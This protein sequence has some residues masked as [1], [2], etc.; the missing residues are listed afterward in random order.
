MSS[1]LLALA[2]MV[3]ALFMGV[4]SPGPSFVMVART[5]M[6]SNRAHGIAASVGMG[7]GG[8]FYA[9][10]ALLGL[11]LVFNAVPA[12]YLMLKFVG[13]AYLI[14]LGVRIWRSGDQPLSI[15][16][17]GHD[18]PNRL[19]KSLLLGLSTQLSNPKTSIV[20]ASVFAAFLPVEYGVSFAVAVVVSVFVMETS[21]YA[22]VSVVLSLPEPRAVYLKFKKVLDRVAGGVM[23]ALGLKL[24]L[25]ATK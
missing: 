24:I 5:S 15:D 14:W 1:Q 9:L 6:S 7:F 13:G 19:R 20:Y 17:A 23:M 16:V 18:K 12:L 11:Q 10:A 25:D 22:L 8:V 2:A 21:W 4:I 3:G